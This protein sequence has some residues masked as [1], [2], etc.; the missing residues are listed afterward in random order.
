MPQAKT[1]LVPAVS[2]RIP[3]SERYIGA[4]LVDSGRLKPQDVEHILRLQREEGLRFGAAAIKL[5]L[6]SKADL[7]FALSRQFDHPCLL[8]GESDVDERVVAAYGPFNAHVESLRALRS[9]LMLRWFEKDAGR[10][11][12]AIMSADRNEGRSFIAANLAVVFSQLGQRTLLIDADMRSPCQHRLFG[13]DNRSG[14]SAILSGRG[15]HELAQR[16]PG[17][18]SLSVLPAGAEPPNP[19]ELLARP[20]FPQL[21]HQLAEEYEVLL[22]DT[23]ASTDYADGQTVA[24]RAGGALLV[25]RPNATRISRARRVCDAVT[26]SGAT[27]VGTVLNQF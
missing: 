21:L 23:P 25:A 24:A 17:L 9:Q 20:R 2:P 22:L 6:L 13:I 14:L 15:S 16:V 7:D 4:T 1:V 18:I 8:R 11:T 12:L 19:L 27:I 5:R 26:T 3:Y 10:K